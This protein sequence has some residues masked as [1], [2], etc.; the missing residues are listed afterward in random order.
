ME[1][2]ECLTVARAEL[3]NALTQIQEELR[4]YPT[5]VSG[6]DAQ[7][8]YLIGQRSSVRN[9]LHELAEPRFVATPRIPE[10]GARVESR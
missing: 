1:F 8:N 5:P 2:E 7:F 6:C 9:A 4:S 3:Q 10:A